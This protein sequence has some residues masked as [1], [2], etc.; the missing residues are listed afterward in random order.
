MSKNSLST[1]PSLP[2]DLQ[3]P[4]R[5]AVWGEARV[6]RDCLGLGKTWVKM[7]SSQPFSASDRDESLIIVMPG[8]GATDRSTWFLRR[9]LRKLDYRVEGWGIGRNLAGRGLIKNLDELSD[10]WD[11]DR[12]LQHRGEGGVPALCDVATDQVL[13]RYAEVQ[14]PIT[15]VGW[16]LGGYVAREVARE[17]PSEVQA[18][19]T[20]GAPVIGGPKY[21]AAAKAFARMGQDLDWIEA[22][23]AKREVKPIQQPITAIYSKSDAVVAWQAAIDHHSP[24]V[25]HIEVNVAHIGMGFNSEVLQHVHDALGN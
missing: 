6:V 25:K 10:R 16:S 21:T 4:L 1:N 14:M 18:V 24:N 13:A 19:I 20:M 7:P 22:E 9:Y 11:I 8:F 5:S 12:N 3:P 15:L 17:C 2:S 23:V